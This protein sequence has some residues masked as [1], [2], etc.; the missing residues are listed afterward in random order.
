MQL[1]NFLKEWRGEQLRKYNKLINS[2]HRFGIYEQDDFEA[3]R[4]QI[5]RYIVQN[6]INRVCE[7]TPE[8][9]LSF[10]PSERGI[11][12]H[13]EVYQSYD[14]QTNHEDIN[15]AIKKA[16]SKVKQSRICRI[17][18]SFAAGGYYG[19]L[20]FRKWL[21]CPVERVHLKPWCG[22]YLKEIISLI[23][24][25]GEVTLSEGTFYIS[26]T[27]QGKSNVVLRGLG[28]ATRI[29]LEAI[30]ED[31]DMLSFSNAENFQVSNILF[32]GNNIENTAGKQSGLIISDC[33]N[34]KV[35][36][37]YFQHF[38]RTGTPSCVGI[39]SRGDNQQGIIEDNWFEDLADGVNLFYSGTVQEEIIITKNIFLST[40]RDY[41]LN[42]GIKQSFIIN[43]IILKSNKHGIHLYGFNQICDNNI[44]ANNFIA[45]ND[46]SNSGND[47]IHFEKLSGSC[48]Y[49][50]ILGNVIKKGS[51]Q[52]YG[53]AIGT[54]CSHNLIIH[55]DL[56][57]AGVSGAIN[58]QGAN[59]IIKDNK[60]YNPVG[61]SSISVGSSPFTYTAG[62]S[63]ET[64]YIKGGNV[65]EIKK[66]GETLFTDTDHT[67]HLEPHEQI[68]IVY[69]SAPTMYK[70]VH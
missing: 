31:K 49:N 6:K 1:S 62:S 20:L 28:W 50:L 4:T 44:I 22:E 51:N 40:N 59:T 58:D 36:H 38:G 55:N 45:D 11:K 27:I 37:C 32:D 17:L 61:L 15:K 29:K 7:Q 63:P 39:G 35:D 18:Q 42:L 3:I 26:D 12:K 66:S 64:I 57:D 10:T 5:E 43:N 23:N 47:G 25:G 2:L 69:S 46:Q 9:A 34:F 68:E 24:P 41:G 33:K 54:D 16:A 13:I 30:N 8:L 14:K 60:G 70:D 52:R 48:N 56:H 65:S 21:G 53:I 19:Y 67:I